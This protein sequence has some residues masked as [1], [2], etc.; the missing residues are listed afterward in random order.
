MADVDWPICALIFGITRMIG[1]FSESARCFKSD[2]V[3]PAAIEINVLSLV[4]WLI[5]LLKTEGSTWG[6]TDRM[7]KSDSWTSSSWLFAAVTLRVSAWFWVFVKLCPEIMIL[8]LFLSSPEIIAV[9]I[10]PTP[11]KPI[12]FINKIPSFLFVHFI[13]KSNNKAF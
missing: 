6:L 8:N 2:K 1:W 11:I 10:F 7:I 4:K 3:S 12:V 9:A 13:I 5:N